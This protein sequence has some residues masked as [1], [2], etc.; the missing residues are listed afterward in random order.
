MKTRL[1]ALLL[2][3][4]FCLSTP[5]FSVE[6]V[7]LSQLSVSALPGP[8]D[9]LP[10]LK[11]TYAS[12]Q[13][14]GQRLAI[15]EFGRVRTSLQIQVTTSGAKAP[16]RFPH[17]LQWDDLKLMYSTRGTFSFQ[18]LTTLGTV[19]NCMLPITLDLD[20]Y[21]GGK[22]AD[23]TYTYAQSAYVDPYGRCAGMGS[24]TALIGYTRVDPK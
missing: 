17:R 19:V 20:L 24:Q 2:A 10:L 15:D 13:W 16:V 18:L 23:A 7:G 4:S 8:L 5:G 1:F 11:S 3:S 9:H 6:A 22:A 21:D 14:K 12:T